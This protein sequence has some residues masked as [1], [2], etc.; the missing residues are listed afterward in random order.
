QVS[1]TTVKCRATVLV[2]RKKYVP[3]FSSTTA[4]SVSPSWSVMLSFACGVTLRQSA[5][6]PWYL[7]HLEAQ[8]CEKT[9]AAQKATQPKRK[10]VG[11]TGCLLCSL[12]MREG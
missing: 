7:P 12:M 9:T 3:F 11:L 2:P 6:H 1:F 5:R 4:T 8:I 10:T